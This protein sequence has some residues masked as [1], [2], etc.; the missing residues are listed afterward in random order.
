M[1]H[2]V[3]RL[4]LTVQVLIAWSEANEVCRGNRVL[5]VGKPREVFFLYLAFQSPLFRQLAV[6]LAAN[7]LAFGVV[8]VL[9]VGKLP[10]VIGVRLT[11][12]EFELLGHQI[13]EST[14]HSEFAVVLGLNRPKC[15]H[16]AALLLLSRV[17]APLR[18]IALVSYFL[19]DLT[20]PLAHPL[21][22]LRAEIAVKQRGQ[23]DTRSEFLHVL[24]HRWGWFLGSWPRIAHQTPIAANDLLAIVRRQ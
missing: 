4:T 24:A 16:T 15:N 6:P 19:G 20:Q 11:R 21:L 8:I 12:T 13:S 23:P 7:T 14:G 18:Q 2:G 17:N 9:R 5:S 10:L 22:L 1:F 3:D